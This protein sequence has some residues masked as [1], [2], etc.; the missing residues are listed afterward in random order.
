MLFSLLVVISNSDQISQRVRRAIPQP[1]WKRFLA[2]LFYNG[3]AGGLVWVALIIIATSF[4]VQEVSHLYPRSF[5]ISPGRPWFGTTAA[6]IFD[7]ALT[8]LFIQRKFLSRRPVKMTG[9]LAVILA[10]IWALAPSIIFFFLNQLTV[11]SF[12][13]LELGNLFNV[14]AM[15]DDARM[16]YHTC[17]AFGWL[18]VII[19]ANASW[20]F[21]MINNFRPPPPNA[22]PV[23]GQ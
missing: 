14:F 20:F 6:Y 1:A 19:L 5:A 21:R 15:H 7:Y 23:I 11:R 2:F 17:F 16:I 13:G 3:A 4:T 12:E 18:A 9:L 8:A 10:S 22:P